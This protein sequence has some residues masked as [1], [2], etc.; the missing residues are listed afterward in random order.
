VSATVEDLDGLDEV[1]VTVDHPAA[2]QPFPLQRGLYTSPNDICTPDIFIPLKCTLDGYSV[3]IGDEFIPA[4][5]RAGDYLITV[6][7]GMTTVSTTV[8]LPAGLAALP[9]GAEINQI[10]VDAS[11]GLLRPTISI[12]AIPG[13][14]G[15]RISIQ[16]DSD[17]TST[18]FDGVATAN[19]S[20]TP[21]IRVGANL[22]EAG[23][24]YRLS[25]DAFDAITVAGSNLR[26]ESAD[27]CYD[28]AT[29]RTNIPCLTQKDVHLVTESDGKEVM[30][31]I[32]R[33]LDSDALFCTPN[34][35][36]PQQCVPTVPVPVTGTVTRG[37]FG[38]FSLTRGP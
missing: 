6:S 17:S 36:D 38:P 24:F 37:S 5:Q 28:P 1:K 12:P 13:A 20:S 15:Y 14:T 23:K 32:G 35:Q 26:S 31:A 25:I 29:G 10:V 18:T 7:D 21:S 27:I 19:L 8:T 2:S 16:N 34:P 9:A 11:T 4:A 30:L 33:V 3:A 22:L